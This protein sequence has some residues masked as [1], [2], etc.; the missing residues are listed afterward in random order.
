MLVVLTE[1]SPK[2]AAAG[3]ARGGE[4]LPKSI[5][6]TAGALTCMGEG[7][8]LA[9]ASPA[10]GPVTAGVVGPCRAAAWPGPTALSFGGSGIFSGADILVLSLVWLLPKE[11]T[12]LSVG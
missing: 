4:K 2:S 3:S 8:A 12:N 11:I 7:R 10:G 6:R 5:S 1:M 9:A